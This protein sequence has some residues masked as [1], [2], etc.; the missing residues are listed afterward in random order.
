MREICEDLSRRSFREF[1]ARHSIGPNGRYRK[2]DTGAKQRYRSQIH[3]LSPKSQQT[4]LFSA[5]IL[6]AAKNAVCSFVDSSSQALFWLRFGIGATLDD[7]PARGVPFRTVFSPSLRYVLG[8]LLL[9]P[10]W[11]Q[12]VSHGTP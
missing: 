1:T 4:V 10:S 5:R 11:R 2:Q 3:L 6:R 9:D 8:R 7:T 12:I